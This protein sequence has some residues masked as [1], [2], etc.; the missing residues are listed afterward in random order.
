MA[1]ELTEICAAAQTHAVSGPPETVLGRVRHGHEQ[2]VLDLLRKNGALSRADL[3]QRSGLS[4]TTLS[5]IVAS[6]LSQRAV[7]TTSPSG[8]GPRG[9]G[10]PAELVTLDPAAGQTIGIDFARRNVFV[11]VANLA[12]EVVGSASESHPQRTPLTRRLDIALG[13]ID[14]IGEGPVNL[15]ALEG[16]GVGVVGPVENPGTSMP[17][18]AWHRRIELIPQVLSERFGVP[19]L[20]DNN[21]RL[22]AVAESIW[23]VGRDHTHLIYVRLSYGVGG[24][25]ILDGALVRGAHGVA[26]EIGHITV[27]HGGVPCSCG[28]RGCLE[29]YASVPAVLAEC[30]RVTGR[31]MRL[32]TA[33]SALRSGDPGVREVFDQ[34]GYRLGV[35]L[36]GICNTFGP[37][38]VVV[39]GELAA[40]GDALLGPANRA[41]EE[42]ALP[43][44]RRGLEVRAA[45]L[46]DGAGALG[47]IALVLHSSPL[48]AG[49]PQPND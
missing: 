7:T 17:V 29:A 43:M 15:G 8:T 21:V 16:V 13:L 5:D 18:T 46:G 35:V 34:A 3:A 39:A 30:R 33:L 6:L 1:E 27:E 10:R 22:S 19:V 14:G 28:G 11:T 9:R 38:V 24:G 45:E 20:V 32:A 37:T 47:G 49:Y 48:L 12:H 40:A 36:A 4:R 42:H 25:M 2:R 41:L 26:G 31:R 23:G 44:V